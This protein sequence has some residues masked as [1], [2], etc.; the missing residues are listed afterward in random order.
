MFAKRD[1]VRAL[2]DLSEYGIEKQQIYTIEAVI[3]SISQD[4]DGFYKLKGVDSLLPI[5]DA[6]PFEFIKSTPKITHLITRSL[7]FKKAKYWDEYEDGYI[8]V[9]NYSSLNKR[10]IV[11]YTFESKKDFLYFMFKKSQ[12]EIEGL[13]ASSDYIAN[14]IKEFE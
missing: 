5:I 12:K 8:E 13:E 11:Y 14:Y 6:L 9:Y 1:C 3:P 2:F 10:K 4:L 7:L